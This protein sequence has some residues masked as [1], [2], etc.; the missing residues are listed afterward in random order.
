MKKR[1]KLINVN[2]MYSWVLKRS[3]ISVFLVFL[4]SVQVLSQ[5]EI[6]FQNK[7]KL[8]Q[9]KLKHLTLALLLFELATIFTY[10]NKLYSYASILGS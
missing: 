2:L 3:L 9:K 6:I 7:K 5:Y 4:V 1:F 10:D 8:M